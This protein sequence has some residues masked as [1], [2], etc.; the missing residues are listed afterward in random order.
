MVKICMALYHAIATAPVGNCIHPRTKNIVVGND[1]QFA[2][3]TDY[4]DD[5]IPYLFAADDSGFALTYTLPKGIRLANY[6]G[7][8]GTNILL[9]NQENL[10]GD[11]KLVG[12]LYILNAEN[13]IPVLTKEGAQTGQ[14]VRP[15]PVYL[16]DTAFIPIPDINHIMSHG[17]QTL[18]IADSYNANDFFDETHGGNH[19]QFLAKMEQLRITG[20]LRW[21]NEERDIHPINGLTLSGLVKDN[22]K[23]G[24]FIK[25]PAFEI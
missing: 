6:Q 20:K 21:L 12:G 4:S 24:P 8:H 9:V 13:F 16:I 14:W 18:Q 2:Y 23:T 3:L 22:K 19:D 1:G 10:I 11:P 25:D 5:N 7:H 15:D 17:V